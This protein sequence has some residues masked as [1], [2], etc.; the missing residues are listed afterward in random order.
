[1]SKGQRGNK[2]A[3]KPK[4]APQSAKPTAPVGTT[5]AR[6]TVAPSRSKT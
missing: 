4:K 5:P 1:M 3:R 6:T 2:E